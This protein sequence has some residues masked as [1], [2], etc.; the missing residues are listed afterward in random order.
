[1]IAL[2][3]FCIINKADE[4]SNEIAERISNA[5]IDYNFRY[6]EKHPELII[7]VGGDGKF[8]RYVNE[9]IEKI[10]NINY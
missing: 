10:E 3:Y 2:K 9:N 4:V 6:D 8:L 7:V 1:M 5:L